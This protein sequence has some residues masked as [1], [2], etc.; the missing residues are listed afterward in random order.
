[1]QRYTTP[2]FDTFPLPLSR[3][4]NENVVSVGADY[5]QFRAN[6]MAR[7]G[8]GLTK[9]YNRF[10]DRYDSSDEIV[11]LRDLH[12]E[13]DRAILDA[14]GWADIVPKY[15]FVLDY[16]ESDEQE[17][18]AGRKRKEP[19]RYRWR[20]ED[21]D[22]VLARLLDLNRQR[23]ADGAAVKKAERPTASASAAK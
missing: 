14:F 9:T 16:E 19:W 22:E 5:Y 15:D 18:P 20:D 6:L 4:E 21:R 1:A 3:S 7:N 23:A 13:M 12:A 10:H 2:C 11:D 8:E 17:S